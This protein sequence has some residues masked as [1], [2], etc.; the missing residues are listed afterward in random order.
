MEVNEIKHKRIKARKGQL[1]TEDGESLTLF[2]NGLAEYIVE[3][4]NGRLEYGQGAQPLKETQAMLEYDR[5]KV[6]E[7][8]TRIKNTLGGYDWLITSRG[9]YAWDDDRWHDEF[10][11]ASESLREDLEPL[12]RI[13]ADW[14]N[15]PTTTEEI[16]AARNRS[17]AAP[18]EQPRGESM[19]VL[20][21]SPDNPERVK[22]GLKRMLGDSAGLADR[23]EGP[24]CPVCGRVHGGRGL[25][26]LVDKAADPPAQGQ[27][28]CSCATA[29]DDSS[30][31]FHYPPAPPQMSA[32]E[33][34]EQWVTLNVAATHPSRESA[35]QRVV[36]IVAAWEAF[37]RQ[38]GEKRNG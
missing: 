24:K 9:C 19:G 2:I 29:G 27:P 21:T 18:P 28:R 5:T 36:E 35:K 33:F 26:G 25:C 12:E 15:C 4:W 23:G 1:V 30:C 3:L 34:A 31:E 10:R 22:A 32:R 37:A 6:A 17:P 11:R 16:Q 13:A 8:I 7:C 38:N 14:R 20:G